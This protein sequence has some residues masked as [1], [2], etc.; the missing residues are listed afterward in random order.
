MTL[1][2]TASGFRYVH[3]CTGVFDVSA[4]GSGIDWYVR[5]GA[6]PDAARSDVAN[7]VLAVALHAAGTLTLH[8]SGVAI[9]SVAIDSAS[10]DG[11]DESASGAVVFLAEKRTGKSTLAAG[12]V[13]A[14]ARLVSDDMLAVV[15]DDEPARGVFLMP[16][17]P[18]LR[19]F[20]DS[21]AHA[22][23]SDTAE[24]GAVR[25]ADGKQ[26]LTSLEH[27]RR[28][29]TPVPL[30]AVYLLTPAVAD[31]ADAAR[32]EPLGAVPAAIALLQHAKLAPLFGGREHPV[33]LDRGVELARRV[34]VYR[35]H[36][37]RDLARLGD[38]AD[39]ILRWHGGHAGADVVAS[40]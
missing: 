2:R 21:A 33:L 26:V 32:R 24:L 38:A 16:G 28:Q 5:P 35:L 12:L 36:V 40:R 6:D 11:A 1:E 9:D 34:P 18:H 23:E 19:L 3:S 14:G 20:D 10:P 7:R 22:L 39:R 8:G 29:T 31:A 30:R 27:A 25:G 13:N 4:D 37:A 17:L 15:P